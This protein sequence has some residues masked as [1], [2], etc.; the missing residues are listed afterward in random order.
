M[1]LLA[2]LDALDRRCS[3]AVHR[4]A[5]GA[6]FD[7]VVLIPALAFGHLGFGA[8]LV[9]IAQLPRGPECVV[10]MLPLIAANFAQSALL[11]VLLGRARPVAPQGV[12]PRLMNVRAHHG[13]Q[14]V[15]K[16]PDRSLRRL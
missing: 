5:F 3:N 4:Q 10:F 12:A 14:S 8:T 1:G 15:H 13:N 2:S 11:K 9:A 7:F 6:L 16:D